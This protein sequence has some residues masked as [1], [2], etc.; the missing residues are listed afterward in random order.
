[1]GCLKT[2]VRVI[3]MPGIKNGKVFTALLVKLADYQD[4]QDA[5]CIV[6]MFISV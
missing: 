5:P 4:L 3:V 2:L 1:M 6:T